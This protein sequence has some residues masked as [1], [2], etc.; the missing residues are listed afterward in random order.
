MVF[1]PQPQIDDEFIEIWGKGLF[2]WSELGLVHQAWVFEH[3]RTFTPDPNG[4]LSCA[5]PDPD[6]NYAWVKLIWRNG[7]K[8]MVRNYTDYDE[9]RNSRHAYFTLGEK[10]QIYLV[11]TGLISIWNMRNPCEAVQQLQTMYKL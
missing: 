9:P 11:D 7:F 5:F 1:P 4:W 8:H 6:K 3:Y 10:D 2:E